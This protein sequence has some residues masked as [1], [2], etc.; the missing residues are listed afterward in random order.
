[1][2]IGWQGAHPEEIVLAARSVGEWSIGEP[3][4]EEANQSDHADNECDPA[5]QRPSG[6]LLHGQP[7]GLGD[8]VIV[9]ARA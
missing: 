1:M 9:V 5:V 8:A 3:G 4:P 2:N 7:A 6:E